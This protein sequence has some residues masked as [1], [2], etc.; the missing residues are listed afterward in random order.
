MGTEVSAW[1]QAQAFGGVPPFSDGVQLNYY[2]ITTDTGGTTA[3]AILQGLGSYVA[4]MINPSEYGV[5]TA[6]DVSGY[7]MSGAI[8]SAT[9]PYQGTSTTG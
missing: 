4:R 5:K 8:P 1:A 7:L 2:P 9:N 6:V 3:S